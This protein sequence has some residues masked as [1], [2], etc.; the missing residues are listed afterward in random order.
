MPLTPALSAAARPPQAQPKAS[1]SS[2]LSSWA[3]VLTLGLALGGG[4][5][6]QGQGV[7]GAGRRAGAAAGAD[8]G[9]HVA[10]DVAAWAVHRLDAAAVADFPAQAAA[11]ALVLVHHADHARGEQLA[12]GGLFHHLGGLDGRPAA[13]AQGLVQVAGIA[14]AA[15]QDRPRPGPP[16]SGRTR[17]LGSSRKLALP[18]APGP[19]YGPP[20]WPRGPRC[21]GG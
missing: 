17:C 16:C 1:T 19:V 14:G 3:K 10:G 4:V 8:H 21:A 20:W 15:G 7:V 11:D 9:V 2:G 18:R 5:V 13:L 6:L 12:R